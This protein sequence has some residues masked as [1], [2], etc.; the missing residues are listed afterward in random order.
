MKR[1]NKIILTGFM[2]SGK[3]AIGKRVAHTFSMPFYD[4]DKVIEEG[5]GMSIPEIFN[6]HGEPYFR[7]LEWKYV[8]K[9]LNK[10]AFVLALG[11]G[12]LE[13][14]KLKSRVLDQSLLIFLD[15]PEEILLERLKRDKKRPMLRNEQGELPPEPVLKEKINTLLDRR[16]PVY[17]Q[18]HRTVVVGNG[19]ERS[20]TTKETIK[21][22]KEYAA[23]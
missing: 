18:A 6:L 10:D 21:T 7:E 20:K 14:E 22:I 5:E 8:N 13:Q 11:G 17:Q 3:S 4:L 9:I 2:G 19:W 16:R 15:V 12:A 23:S 1:I